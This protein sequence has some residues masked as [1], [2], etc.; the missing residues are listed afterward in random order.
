VIAKIAFVGDLMDGVKKSHS[1][2]ASH[3]A[4]PAADTPLSIHQGNSIGGLVGCP[5]RADLNAGRIFALVTKF[6]HKESLLNIFVSYFLELSRAQLQSSRGKPISGF[7][8]SI[9]KYPAVFGHNISFHPGPGDIRFKGNLVFQLTGFN[10]EAAAD[11]TVGIY[12]EPPAN[13][14]GGGGPGLRE[15]ENFA[16]LFGQESPRSSFDE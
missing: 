12:E 2:R 15:F 8:G 9:H 16:G 6:R 3:D 5:Y 11:T 13:R 14:L 7:L 4:I 1:V 10:A